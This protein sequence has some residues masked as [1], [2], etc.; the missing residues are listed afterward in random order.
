MDELIQAREYFIKLINY[1]SPK[2]VLVIY[3]N[4][5]AR[6]GSY[7]AKNLDSEVNQLL[8][9]NALDLL[10]DTGFNY[11]NKQDR[12]RTFYEPIKNVCTDINI[13][14]T[15]DWKCRIGKTI[16]AHPLA[17]SSSALK[18]VD[19]AVEYFHDTE[20]E[21]FDCVVLAHTHH[22]GNAPKGYIEMYEQ[23]CCCDISKLHYRDGKF[24]TPQ[25]KGFVYLCQDKDGNI[26]KDSTKLIK[27]D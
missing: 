27:L 15:N 3:G 19:K 20:K 24:G 2:K 11:Y 18:T 7:L 12:I 17:F 8:P 9:D 6:L 14:N 13:V 21:V 1:I 25:Q 5:E 22:R 10:F 16:F 4:H 23:G 26:I